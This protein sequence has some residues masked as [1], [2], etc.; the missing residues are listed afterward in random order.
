MDDR[1]TEVDVAE[2][3]DEENGRMDDEDD[4]RD[5]YPT[6]TDADGSRAALAAS[7]GEVWSEAVVS[8]PPERRGACVGL[9]AAVLPRVA[10]TRAG[11]Q[12]RF[13]APTT[14]RCFTIF[15]KDCEPGRGGSLRCL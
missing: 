5:G 15:L 7:V 6:G 3:D 12:S 2:S 11:A 10:A 1:G 13:R 8:G 14:E 4:T 9:L